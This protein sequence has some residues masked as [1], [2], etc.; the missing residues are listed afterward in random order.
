MPA[1]SGN[2]KAPLKAL[3]FDSY[4]DPYRGVIIMMRV[5]EGEVRVGD[6]VLMMA[7]NKKY[8]V[9]ELGIRTP[10]EVKRDVLRAGEVGYLACLLYTSRCV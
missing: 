3:I 6:E 8:L 7:T 1:P 10:Q 9:T 4:Y 5:K 2:V